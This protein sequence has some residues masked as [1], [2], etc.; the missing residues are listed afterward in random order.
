MDKYYRGYLILQILVID[1]MLGL[2]D[3]FPKFV[4][5]YSNLKKIMENSVKKY[6]KE[7][8]QRQFPTIKNI[9]K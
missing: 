2:G 5:K 1:D 4:K 3:F 7:V 6:F 8:K 9:Y